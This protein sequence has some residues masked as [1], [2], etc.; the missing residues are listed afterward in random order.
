MLQ[1]MRMALTLHRAA[2]HDAPAPS[3]AQVLRMAT[4]YG[5]A[6]TPFKGRIGNL[7]VGGLA[8]IVLL[9]WDSVTR[10]WQDPA[11]PLEEVLIRR[12][13]AG[14]VET[15]MVGGEVIYHQGQFARIDREEI[16]A[17]LATA[18]KRPDTPDEVA[19]R[20]LAK[21]ALPVVETFYADWTWR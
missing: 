6:T 20:Q 11:I 12:A 3:A 4:E 8:D 14:A 17:A 2:G 21:A 7:K 9:D 19:R 18:M 13:R 1:E 15:V 16:L 5:A 10:P